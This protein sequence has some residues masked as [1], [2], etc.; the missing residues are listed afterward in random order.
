MNSERLTFVAPIA[1]DRVNRF[2]G[3]RPYV[4]TGS[5][6]DDG[7]ISEEMVTFSKRPSRA[8]VTIQDG[9]LCFARMFGTRKVFRFRSEHDHLILSTGFAVLRPD[10]LKLHPDYLYHFLITSSFQN[11]KDAL[12]SGATQK[13][14]TN[15]GIALIEIPIPHDLDE[16]KRIAAVLDKA[17]ALRRQRQESLRFIQKLLQSTFIDMFGDP[18]T[19]SKN[20]PLRKL[21]TFGI[22]QTGN[23]PPRSNRANYAE[24]GLEWIKTDNI[25]EDQV[26]VSSSRENLSAAGAKIA[27]IAPPGSLLV[28]CIAGSE[29]SIGRAALTDQKVAFNQ[30]INAITPHADTSPLFLYFLLKIARRQIQTAAGKGM[31][32]MINKSTFESLEFIAPEYD[33]QLKF[34][35]VAQ[36]M[37]EQRND[38]QDQLI[39]LERFFSSLQQRAFRGELDLNRLEL[40]MDSN[41]PPDIS[42]PAPA[43]PQNRYIR[44]GSFIAPPDIE[45]QM[46]ELEDKLDFGKGDAITWDENYFKYRILSQV[47]QPPFSFAQI[48]E[49]VQYDI[50]EPDYETVKEKVFEYV[51]AGILEQQFDEERK[52]IVFHPRS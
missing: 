51:A 22:V 44:P 10:K 46:M 4:A 38:C 45:A 14:I 31:K 15:S 42:P 43:V 21:G 13:A 37:I 6:D 1:A 39:Q 7:Y 20:L 35:R 25:I 18:L 47:L 23:T 33:Q 49:A 8:D 50:E 26:V 32:K 29:K 2:E 24:T 17:D 12:C 11:Q 16:Q 34:E 19:N 28:A 40:D 48:W 3:M 36:R 27:R 9:D 41:T 52:E 30:Q 5:L